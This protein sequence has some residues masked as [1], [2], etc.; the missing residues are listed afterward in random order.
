MEMKK[1]QLF[2]CLL[3]SS[4]LFLTVPV[5]AQNRIFDNAGLLNSGEKAELEGLLAQFASNYNFNL[6]IV[7]END[8]GGASPM[9]YAD[10][11]FDYKG[12]IDTDGCLFL[13]VTGSRDWWFS[14]S[15]R[16][17]KILNSSAFNKLK[18]DVVKFLKKDNPAQAYRVF[19]KDWGEFLALDAEG[20][21][22]NFI[23]AYS[24]QLFIGAWVVSLLIALF[25]VYLMKLKMNNV[26]PKTEADSFIVPGSLAFT[27][28]SD[29]FLFCTITKTEIQSESSS[30]G[31]HTSSS[32]RSHGGGGG[33]Y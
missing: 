12:F 32:G 5:F 33:K 2:I 29:T 9:G 21:S 14:T 18:N 6:V 27:R 31:S 15:G 23:R 11:F 20:K 22:Y 26:R 13:L 25:A 24:I 16:G 7:T 1:N 4:F 30:S 28:Q 10:D 8:I 3:T 19:I 17:E